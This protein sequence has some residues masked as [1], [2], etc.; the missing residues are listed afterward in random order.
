M[1]LY[2]GLSKTGI[3]SP[4]PELKLSIYILLMSGQKCVN[5]IGIL[6]KIGQKLLHLD[7]HLLTIFRYRYVC[8]E[9][10]SSQNVEQKGVAS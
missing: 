10:V 8:V 5:R 7:W 3:Q 4:P 1:K 2:L 6:T 9:K